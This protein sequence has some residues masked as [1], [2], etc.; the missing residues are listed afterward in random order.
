MCPNF[1]ALIFSGLLFHF[2]PASENDESE[3]EGLP[4]EGKGDVLEDEKDTWDREGFMCM[5]EGYAQKE[6]DLQCHEGIDGVLKQ[7][8]SVQEESEDEEDTVDEERY[9]SV[10]HNR[11]KREAFLEVILKYMIH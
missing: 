9:I 6:A 11:L 4:N 5:M 8:K 3:V 1:L 2:T 10:L 7:E